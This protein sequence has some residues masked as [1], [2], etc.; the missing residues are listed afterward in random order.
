MHSKVNM[1]VFDIIVK[2][3]IKSVSK[4]DK[5]VMKVDSL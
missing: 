2:C 1:L 3:T 5:K 4:G